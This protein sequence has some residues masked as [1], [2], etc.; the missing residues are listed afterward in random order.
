M[1]FSV[2]VSCDMRKTIWSRYCYVLTLVVGGSCGPAEVPERSATLSSAITDGTPD[3]EHPSV[4]ML[5]I[6]GYPGQST[7]TLVGKRTVLTAAHAI[8][9]GATHT[10]ELGGKAYTVVKA[11]RHPDWDGEKSD[12][13]DIGLLVL[14]SEPPEIPSIVSSDPPT[15][16]QKIILVGYGDTAYDAEDGGTKRTAVNYIKDVL[17]TTF[18]YADTG[19]GIGNT[20]VGDSGGPA[21]GVNNGEEVQLGVTSIGQIPCGTLSVD[22]RV[23]AYLSWLKTA[24]SGDLCQGDREP[25]RVEIISPADGDAVS[26]EVTVTVHASDNIGVAE[27]ALALDGEI[28]SRLTIPP[29]LFKLSLSGPTHVIVVTARD[30]AG[31]EGQAAATVTVISATDAGPI[32]GGDPERSGD[33]GFTPAGAHSD[34]AG[35]ILLLAAFLVLGLL[36]RR[37]S[38]LEVPS[39]LLLHD[40]R[41]ADA[42]EC[43]FSLPAQTSWREGRDAGL[44]AHGRGSS[45]GRNRIA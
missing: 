28:Q 18:S 44:A 19:N 36:S 24:S 14:G 32:P 7:A 2:I 9:P 21:F 5:K 6:A 11:L 26:S 38:A 34:A 3:L 25:P 15:K 1:R 43:L 17:P 39:K 22:T 20:C 37:L 30:Q 16:G 13:H 8:L 29:Y 12:L 42:G 40:A 31:N 45:S 33:C 35:Q 27:V 4:G 41:V 10:F 23:D